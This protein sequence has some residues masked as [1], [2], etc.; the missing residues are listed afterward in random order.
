MTTTTVGRK[1]TS[2]YRSVTSSYVSVTS[3]VP[4]DYMSTEPDLVDNETVGIGTGVNLLLIY[5][6]FMLVF[7]NK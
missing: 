5:L 6:H 3:D 1:V 4:R 7:I 2:P